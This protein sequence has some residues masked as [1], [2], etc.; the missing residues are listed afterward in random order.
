M[1]PGGGQPEHPRST[2]VLP[3]RPGMGCHTSGRLVLEMGHRLARA[4]DRRPAQDIGE[5]TASSG[6]AQGDEVFS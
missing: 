6:P 2:V 4:R 1:A 5:G 3:K